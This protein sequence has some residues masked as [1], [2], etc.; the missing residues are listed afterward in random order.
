MESLFFKKVKKFI[1]STAFSFSFPHCVAFRRLLP[2]GGGAPPRA[3]TDLRIFTIFLCFRALAN[4]RGV[5]S[6]VPK[7]CLVVSLE[8]IPI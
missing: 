7:R 1:Y 8:S 5:V 3:P 4:D 6:G 2:A